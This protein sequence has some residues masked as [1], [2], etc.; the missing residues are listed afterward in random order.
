MASPLAQAAVL[1][2]TP[3]LTSAITP[4]YP[5]SNPGRQRRAREIAPNAAR[6]PITIADGAVLGISRCALNPKP[7]PTSGWL[8]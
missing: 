4:P 2:P 3:T 5:N 7:K 6:R 1:N 8:L